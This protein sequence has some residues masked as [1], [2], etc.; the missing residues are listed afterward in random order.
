MILLPLLLAATTSTTNNNSK[1]HNSF[2]LL[3]LN[4]NDSPQSPNNLHYNVR[5]ALISA[6]TKNHG[7]NVHIPSQIIYIYK[8]DLY[9]LIVYHTYTVP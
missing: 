5:N 3:P 7:L 9:P 6:W 1:N 2:W 8:D 4:A